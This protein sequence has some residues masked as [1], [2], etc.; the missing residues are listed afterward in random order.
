MPFLAPL[1]PNSA[2]DYLGPLANIQPPRN[3]RPV[4]VKVVLREVSHFLLSEA[5]GICLAVVHPDHCS[6]QS[7]EALCTSHT[8]LDEEHTHREVGE[9]E[10]ELLIHSS[11]CDLT[12]TGRWM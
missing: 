6:P 7:S 11:K 1:H 12:S 10:A 9:K 3:W 4:Q 2:S 8:D 5:R